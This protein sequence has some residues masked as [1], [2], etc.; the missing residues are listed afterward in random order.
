MGCPKRDALLF[1]AKPVCKTDVTQEFDGPLSHRH[2]KL[3]P[4]NQMALN[5]KLFQFRL[6]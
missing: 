5:V 1:C 6:I 4:N 3:K 2:L